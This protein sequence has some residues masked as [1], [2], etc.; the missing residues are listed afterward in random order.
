MKGE[1]TTTNTNDVFV[2]E[3]RCYRYTLHC[4]LQQ[5]YY[6]GKNRIYVNIELS[7]AEV[8]ETKTDFST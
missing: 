8:S 2:E 4:T 6:R 5:T 3:L 1:L 7:M